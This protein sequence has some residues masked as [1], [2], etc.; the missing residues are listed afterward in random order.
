M[1]ASMKLPPDSMMFVPAKEA[2]GWDEHT[3]PLLAM[4]IP[5]R[6]TKG[7]ESAFNTL[8]ITTWGDCRRSLKY[9]SRNV[10]LA[11]QGLVAGEKR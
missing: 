11:V 5:V 3:R 9:I 8:S 2:R 4:A 10:Q 7:L 6:P 1:A